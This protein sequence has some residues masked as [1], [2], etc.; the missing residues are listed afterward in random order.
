MLLEMKDLHMYYGASHALQGISL[1]VAEGELVPL[2]GAQPQGGHVPGR[3]HSG[4][5]TGWLET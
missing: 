5:G 3:A 2:R 4:M 1:H